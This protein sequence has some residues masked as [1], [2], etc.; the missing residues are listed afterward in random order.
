MGLYLVE[1]DGREG[2]PE[3][4]PFNKIMVTAA[5][6]AIPEGLKQQLAEGGRMMIPV[7]QK[8]Q[9]LVMGE[10]RNGIFQETKKIA[11]RFVPL[12]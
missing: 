1:G 5:A 4:A 2:W 8:T 3:K 10:N 9:K 6:E 12:V 7:G 11:V